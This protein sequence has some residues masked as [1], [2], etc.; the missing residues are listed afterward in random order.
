M[1]KLKL[2]N[3]K[4]IVVMLLAITILA[5]ILRLIGINNNN[6]LWFDEMWSLVAASQPFPRGIINYLVKN[7]V[8]VP[9]YFL[10]LHFWIKMF[11]SSDIVLR[12]NSVLFGILNIPVIY[13][14][15]KEL[16]SKKTGLLAALFVGINSF[17]IYYSQEVRFYILLP[18]LASLSIL[19]MLKFIKHSDKKNLFLLM[20]TNILI[21]F[22]YTI[23]IIFITFEILVFA[24]Y[25][26][27]KN[28]SVLK[29]FLLSQI[30]IPAA[31]L[32]TYSPFLILQMKMVK[33]PFHSHINFDW[34]NL[35]LFS[36]NWFS[37]IIN[38][39]FVNILDYFKFLNSNY[40]LAGWFLT[41]VPIVIALIGLGNALRHKN[42]AKNIFIIA[43]LFF[44]FQLAA[45]SLGKLA[46][47]SRY[48]IMILPLLIL[49]V[50]YGLLSI[51]NKSLS[52]TLIVLFISTNI[53]Y[54]LFSPQSI[55]RTNREGG[56][57]LPFLALNNLS[58]N[59]K[60]IVF[61]IPSGEF[62]KHYYLPK[63]GKVIDFSIYKMPYYPDIVTGNLI[64]KFEIDRYAAFKKY[65]INKTLFP[66]MK[67][68]FQTNIVDKLESKRY[69]IIIRD[70]GDFSKTNNE[71]FDIANSS[72]RYKNADLIG[73]I[74][75]KFI[76]D[77]EKLSAQ[78]YNL[79][80]STRKGWWLIEVYQN[81]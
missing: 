71:M 69:F 45:V 77:L 68:Y 30:I 16:D 29:K 36:Q 72:E 10:F 80:S 81:K 15:G 55:L 50:A 47:I 32:L 44:I 11:G 74:N 39:Q 37:P 57:N 64:E 56:Y 33:D 52:Y 19:F 61:C 21:I 23:G 8:H 24:L 66:S 58:L 27:S 4:K 70:Y 31:L 75:S 60:D 59:S 65:F 38:G 53:F 40:G 22:T 46:L 13:L 63:Y 73:M 48:T 1:G 62:F 14:A 6:G 7:D 17:L 34:S 12:L 76:N 20:L 25:F 42:L 5:L 78:R 51:K 26:Y 35:Y 18:L 43:F 2:D 49:V 54:L 41:A 9:F 28:K 3:N 67:N 79:I